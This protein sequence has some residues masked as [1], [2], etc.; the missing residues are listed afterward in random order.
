MQGFLGDMIW[1]VYQSGLKK[2]QIPQHGE[3][4]TKNRTQITQMKL[5][6]RETTE[7]KE[8]ENEVLS[9]YNLLASVLD[10]VA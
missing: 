6:Y 5:I 9:K 8:V 3:A 2:P 1:C 7:N 10:S 4:T